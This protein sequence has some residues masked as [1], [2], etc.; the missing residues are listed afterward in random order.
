V[1]GGASAYYPNPPLGEWTLV[2]WTYSSSG[3]GQLYINGSAYGN[4]SGGGV[5]A[6]NSAPINIRSDVSD[7]TIKIDE[8]RIYNRALSADEV[9]QLYLMGN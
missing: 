6:T 4:K 1:W 5:L 7:A 3:G 2:T 8:V 9:K